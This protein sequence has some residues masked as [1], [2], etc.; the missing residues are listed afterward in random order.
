LVI[1]LT[2]GLSPFLDAVGRVIWGVFVLEFVLRVALAPH[3]LVFLRR[4]LVTVVT[5]AL[6]AVRTL[7]VFRII[8]AFRLAPVARGLRLLRLITSVNR[9]MKALGSAM[10]RRGLGYVVALTTIVVVAGAAGMYAFEKDVPGGLHSYGVAFWWTAMLLTSIGSEYW[11]K[12]GEGRL[13]CFL[14]SLYG[15]AVFGY[16]TA[17]LA[18]FFIGRDAEDDEAE[19]ASAESIRRLRDEIHELRNEIGLLTRKQ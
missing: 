16:M 9:G 18:S 6:P 11:P 14:L 5:L 1:E 2:R 15:F 7:R 13:L 3:K 19:L 8:T 10:A 12:T 4:N 17:S